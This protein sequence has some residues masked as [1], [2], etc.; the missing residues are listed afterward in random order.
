M[1]SECSGRSKNIL[2]S[3]PTEAELPDTPCTYILTP[4]PQEGEARHRHVPDPPRP[5]WHHQSTDLTENCRLEP[6]DW[7]G[8]ARNI[9][10]SLIISHFWRFFLFFSLV[11]YIFYLSKINNFAQKALSRR[12]FGLKMGALGTRL[13]SMYG[14]LVHMV[15]KHL[16]RP[17][18]PS[19]HDPKSGPKT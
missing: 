10:N 17:V 13:S 12:L 16:A 14:N 18:G 15:L 7:P 19:V 4:D 5:I 8:R 3:N 11:K 1:L 2:Y 9:P 6:S